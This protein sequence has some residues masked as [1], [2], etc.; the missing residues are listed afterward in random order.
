MKRPV[1]ERF[2]EKVD[3]SGDCWM[4]TASIKHSGYG[5]FNIDG[6]TCIAHRVAYELHTG[7]SIPDG[8]EIDHICRNRACVR[9]EHLRVATRKQNMENLT[10]KSASGYRGVYPHRRKWCVYVKHNG[11]THK[12]Y[13][14]ATPEEADGAARELRAFLFTHSD[15]CS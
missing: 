7:G 13:S 1:A 4:W 5:N 9:P 2:W 3:K 10:A 6:K 12:L 11:K 14:F 15:E 8:M